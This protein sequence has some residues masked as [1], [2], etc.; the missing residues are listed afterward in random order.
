MATISKAEYLQRY[1][2]SHSEKKKK[3][4]RPTSTA[5]NTRTKIIDDDLDLQSFPTKNNTVEDEEDDAPIVA[6]FVD[7][8]PEYVQQ[9]EKYREGK[10]KAVN[11]TSDKEGNNGSNCGSS[12]D[13]R[14][15]LKGAVNSGELLSRKRSRHDSDSDQS[16]P[17]TQRHNSESDQSLHVKKRYDSDSNQSP[18]RRQTHD[19]ASDQPLPRRQRLDSDSDQSPPRRQRLDPDSDQSPP[20]RQRHN[21]DSDQS[22]PRR[23]RRNSDSDQSPPR[24]QR[25]NS[26]SDQS[27]P[28]RQRHNSDSDQSPPR[29]KGHGSDVKSRSGNSN[30]KKTS[31]E[32]S[33]VSKAKLNIDSDQSLPR[34]KKKDSDSDQ[35]PPRRQKPAAD[36]DQSPP[37]RDRRGLGVSRFDKQNEDS[38][39]AGKMQKTL[40][41]KK[42]G[43][44]SAKD[45][46]E[47]A[48]ILKRKEDEAFRRISLDQLGKDA[49]TVFRDKSG[50]KRNF[51]KEKEMSEE[52]RKREEEK[53]QKY[54]AWSK[55]LKQQEEKQQLLS[56][57]L[58]EA[59]KP[60]ARH[61]DDED[62]DQMMREQDREGD[63]MLAFIKKKKNKDNKTKERPKY[64][65]APPPPN[66]FNI[67]PGYRWDGV[68]RSNGFEKQFFQKINEKKAMVEVAY[69]WSTEDM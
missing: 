69:K 57:H 51:K 62:L 15:E 66:R 60:L 29:R 61:K 19:S 7:E 14:T 41:G 55:G 38:D 45:M 37:R 20:R 26:D 2:S 59:S 56:D 40:S 58:Y 43:L 44:S 65:G 39:S 21:S 68:D 50:R 22:P 11:V 25:H 32:S 53:Q 13:P 1:L 67:T 18:P 27:L 8:R 12:S 46:R 28:R 49:N 4:K 6:E 64:Q 17:G 54:K 10:W 33:T 31:R 47:E 5:I 3:K 30:K 42:A 35:S 34:K 23:Q 36:S 9:M 16:L 24:R 52:E 48:E 63:P